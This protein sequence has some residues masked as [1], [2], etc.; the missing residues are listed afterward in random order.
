MLIHGGARGID[1]MCEDWAR[2]RE[3]ICVR[4]PAQWSKYGTRAGMKRNA[5]MAAFSQANVVVVFEGG[6]GTLNMLRIARNMD[7]PKPIILLPDGEFWK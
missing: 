1:T 7:D 6:R 3:Q 5:E 4:I 2:E